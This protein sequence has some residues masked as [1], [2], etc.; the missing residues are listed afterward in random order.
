MVCDGI[1]GDKGNI[2]DK[3]IICLEIKVVTLK[4]S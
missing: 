2:G 4:Q 1:M 3:Q